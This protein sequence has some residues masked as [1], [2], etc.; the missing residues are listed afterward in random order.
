MAFLSLQITVLVVFALVEIALPFF[1]HKPQAVAVVLKVKSPYFPLPSA[2][3]TPT[4][5]KYA[6]ICLKMSLQ[7][8]QTDIL[9]TSM[10]QYINDDLK[11]AQ[12]L[13]R[14]IDANLVFE[15]E[16]DGAV[17]KQ[18]LLLFMSDTTPA[19][20]LVESKKQIESVSVNSTLIADDQTVFAL[21]R[22]EKGPE[23]AYMTG[24]LKIVGR[25]TPALKVKNL[26][27][28]SKTLPI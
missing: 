22:G 28:I 6:S 1:I 27:S 2:S 26:I 21:L 17:Q 15:I 11:R 19:I 25:R 12:G 9:F 13:A 16:K 8:L 24:A 10:Q 14:D 4:T 3:Q 7:P 20:T 23:F 18:W 5:L